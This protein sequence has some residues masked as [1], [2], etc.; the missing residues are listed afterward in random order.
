MNAAIEAAR[1][2]EAGK[3][4]A[5][6][7]GEIRQLAEN[8]S[9][10]SKTISGVLKSIKDA[11]DKITR[12]TDVVLGKFDAIGTGVK[13][14]A[15][16][17]DSILSAMEE[18]GHGS[19]Q[20]LRAVGTVNEV[21]H[22]VKEAARRLVETSKENMHKTDSSESQSFTDALTGVR[23]RKYFD[24]SAERELRYCVDENRNFTLIMFSV[25]NLRH[26]ADEHGSGIRDDVLKILTMRAR[27][28]LKQGTLV[29]RYSDEEFII[30]LP[31][32]PQGTATKLAEQVQKKIKDA[33]F[34]TRG[35]RLDVSISLG[36]AS[37]TDGNNTLNGIVMSAEKALASA[38]ASGSNKIAS[39]W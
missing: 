22:K 29:A 10:Q 6:V 20:I 25:D 17:E 16:Q 7:A 13:T 28:S 33:P 30:T 5:V 9:N 21:T 18:Q 23:N 19:K 39:G 38:K 32:V 3:G 26:I 11:I 24:D 34:A 1:A 35:I 2:G 8:S 12:S 37:K 36:L 27:N 15:V 14:V 31:N 4:F